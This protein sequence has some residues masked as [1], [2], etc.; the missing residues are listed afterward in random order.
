MVTKIPVTT[1]LC[2]DFQVY[3][4]PVQITRG[5]GIGDQ[6]ISFNDGMARPESLVAQTVKNTPAMQETWVRSLSWEDPLEKGKATRSGTLA[7]RISMDCIVHG[8]TKSRKRLSDFLFTS[9]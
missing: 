9:A 2:L 3:V 6:N 8:V 7:W 4:L 1:Y 5:T